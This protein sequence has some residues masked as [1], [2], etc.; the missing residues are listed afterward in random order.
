MF[1]LK[2]MTEQ[3]LREELLLLTED[4]QGDVILM[5]CL[6]QAPHDQFCSPTALRH[7]W[8]RLDD[9]VQQ[10]AEEV[11]RVSKFLAR[12]PPLEDRP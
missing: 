2:S 10:H 1:R 6:S 7:L 12:V 8:E 3:E 9:Y 5:A 11:A 4:L